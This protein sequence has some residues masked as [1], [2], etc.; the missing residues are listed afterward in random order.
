MVNPTE[1]VAA[2]EA[3]A[4]EFNLYL[5][6]TAGIS[7]PA[8]VRCAIAHEARD[9]LL[10][11]CPDL[12]SNACLRPGSNIFDTLSKLPKKCGSVMNDYDFKGKEAVIELIHAVMNHQG[13]LVD[14]DWCDATIKNLDEANLIPSNITGDNRKHLLCSAFVEILSIT[15]VSTALHTTFLALEGKKVIELPKLEAVKDL[16]PIYLDWTSLLKIPPKFNSDACMLPYF[17]NSYIN[18][19]SLEYS[20]IS[21]QGWTAM[22]A[23]SENG[24]HLAFGWGGEDAYYVLK[25]SGVLYMDASDLLKFYN[26]KLN[27]KVHCVDSF[28]RFD[29]ETVATAVATAH[30]CGF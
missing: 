9:A 16:S 12:P 4:Q 1:R 21:T 30:D 24:P 7:L 6:E 13:R 28:D 17:L 26:T 14:Q 8:K 5:T 27:P 3:F 10:N 23:V 22:K 2:F 29:S 19:E 18:T 20:K 15:S 25:T 11:G